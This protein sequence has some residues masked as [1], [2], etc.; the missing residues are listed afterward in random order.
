MIYLHF[1]IQM[2]KNTRCC[3]IWALLLG[4]V[5]VHT[6]PSKVFFWCR[7]AR[8]SGNQLELTGNSSSGTRMA[9]KPIV[10]VNSKRR[11]RSGS[12]SSSNSDHSPP[13]PPHRAKCKSPHLSDIIPARGGYSVLV[14][15]EGD[16]VREV[17]GFPTTVLSP[18]ER[19]STV[20]TFIRKLYH[21]EETC[22]KEVENILSRL[23]PSKECK[24]RHV[25]E[26]SKKMNTLSY[27]V[28]SLPE[29]IFKKPSPVLARST[30]GPR[31]PPA[32][33]INTP[34]SARDSLKIINHLQL[35]DSDCRFVRGISLVALASEYSVKKLRREV[36]GNTGK[37]WVEVE[38]LSFKQ[39]FRNNEQEISHYRNNQPAKKEVFVGKIKYENIIPAVA[40]FASCVEDYVDLESLENCPASLKGCAV[41][42]TGN[43]S[44]QGYTREGLRFVNRKNA[45]AG[46]KVFVT[47]LMLGTDKSLSLF[48]KQAIFSSLSQLRNLTSIKI[49]GSERKLVKFSCMDYEAA[50]EEVGT[51]V[52]SPPITLLP[53]PPYMPRA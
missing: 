7:S 1:Q 21:L 18:S 22:V 23:A 33:D 48:Q 11:R 30:P 49:G 3:L 32:P 28:N 8:V 6:S 45:N 20:K 13:P 17:Y 12:S 39:W 46:N 38:Q 5:F 9:T 14:T 42:I 37:G 44:G 26:P 47:T 50:A 53:P 31:L 36:M 4:L 40:H 10:V 29:E 52:Q 43:D 19:E 34:R 2:F 15:E 24:R 25:I 41:I 35:S 51:Q 16:T 27:N